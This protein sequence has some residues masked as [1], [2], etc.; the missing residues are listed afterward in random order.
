MK[1]KST[2]RISPLDHVTLK[3][4]ESGTPEAMLAEVFRQVN[5]YTL[6]NMEMTG[7][8]LL[9]SRVYRLL[10]EEENLPVIN[11]ALTWSY[12]YTPTMAITSFIA[13]VEPYAEKLTNW[14][15]FLAHVTQVLDDRPMA[16][17]GP[18]EPADGGGV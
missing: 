15:G 10:R 11:E 16:L 1:E 2:E 8:G 14:V 17:L 13:L 18:F 7:F 9:N 12:V 6:A 3:T 4:Y 5:K